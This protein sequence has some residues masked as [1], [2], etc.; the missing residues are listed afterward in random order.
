MIPI[1]LLY[2][3]S[4]EDMMLE[5]FGDAYREYRHVVPM[6]VPRPRPATA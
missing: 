5:T 4:E 3:R 1:Y 6:L 2:I